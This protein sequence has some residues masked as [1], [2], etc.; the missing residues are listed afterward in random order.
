MLLGSLDLSAI[1]AQFGRN[2]IELELAIDLIFGCAG[3]ALVIVQAKQP[4]LAQREP[5]AQRTLA[6]R[7]VVVLRSGEVLH[8]RAI[9]FR[10]QGAHIHLH[11]F[12]QFE[13]HFV[14]A[15]G[16]YFDDSRKAQNFFDQPSTLLVINTARPGDQH[17]EITHRLPSAAQRTGR[18]NL[19]NPFDMLQMLGQLLRGSIGFV[20]Q[21]ATGNAPVVLDRFQD[22]LLALFAE[23]R[24]FAKFAFARKFLH[25]GKITYL[26]GAP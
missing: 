16:Q 20:K 12:A 10:R 11:S 13:T 26:E 15:F 5:H 6:Q 4:V 9:G 7:D 17:I 25:A 24:Q 23:A 1:L 8:R 14:V 18:R 2:G 3:N 22:F 19:L 21:E